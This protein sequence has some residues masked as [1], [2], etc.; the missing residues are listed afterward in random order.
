MNMP[1]VWIVGGVDK[2]NDYNELMSLV[3]EKVKAIVCLGVDNKKN[4]DVF[5]NVVDVVLEVTN[6]DDAVRMAATN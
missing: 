3:R 5:G 1:T 4:N 2:G 6:M